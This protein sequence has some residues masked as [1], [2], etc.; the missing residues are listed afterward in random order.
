M[1]VRRGV[2]GGV[3]VALV[4]ALAV[5][6]ASESFWGPF[7]TALGFSLVVVATVVGLVV[8]ANRR[9]ASR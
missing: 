2:V 8:V 3:V 6:N 9:G 1:K 5:G 4:G 7:V